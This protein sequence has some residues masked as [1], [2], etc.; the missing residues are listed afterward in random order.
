MYLKRRAISR[1]IQYTFLLRVISTFFTRSTASKHAIACK[2]ESY[3]DFYMIFFHGFLGLRLYHKYFMV[4]TQIFSV[5]QQKFFFDRF[6]RIAKKSGVDPDPKMDRDP[7]FF[8]S[9]SWGRFTIFF[10]KDRVF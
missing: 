6:F 1:E 5:S 9:R 3:Y 4:K 10:L 7:F 8:G 2:N